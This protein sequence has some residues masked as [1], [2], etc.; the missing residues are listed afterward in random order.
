MVI[1][2][3]FKM[4]IMVYNNLM[5]KIICFNKMTLFYH[6]VVQAQMAL[7]F[8]FQ[9]SIIKVRFKFNKP[10]RIIITPFL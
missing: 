4:G 9:I 7:L 10:L 3:C 1:N 2:K 6:L 8:N 5:V